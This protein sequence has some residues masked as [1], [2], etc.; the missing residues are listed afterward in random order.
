MSPVSDPQLPSAPLRP[1]FEALELAEKAEVFALAVD[2][3]GDVHL[4]LADG[5]TVTGYVFAADAA[6]RP[7]VLRLYPREGDEPLCLAWEQVT[8]LAFAGDDAQERAVR[9][10]RRF[11]ERRGQR[12]R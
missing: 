2:H 6:A 9:V 11:V 4:T 3:R 7:P 5:S 10:W 12:G 1:A 8:G